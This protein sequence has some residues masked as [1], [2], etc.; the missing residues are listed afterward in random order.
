ME[1]TWSA[2][3]A[4]TS[5]CLPRPETAETSAKYHRHLRQKEDLRGHLRPSWLVSQGI[6]D[7]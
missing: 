7:F 1:Q 2:P 4:E 5:T 3:R 6:T